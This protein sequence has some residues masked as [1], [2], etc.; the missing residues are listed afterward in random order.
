MNAQHIQLPDVVGLIAF[1]SFGLWWVFFPGS[2]IS[3]YKWFHRG[4]GTLPSLLGVRLAGA[5]WI[6]LVVAVAWFNSKRASPYGQRFVLH[7]GALAEA[8]AQRHRLA[9]EGW[10]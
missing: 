10:E 5:L 7:E 9:S 2:V 3:F 4:K 6:L 1:L 8:E